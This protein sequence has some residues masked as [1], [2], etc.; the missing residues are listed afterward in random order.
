MYVVF[1][2]LF[3]LVRNWFIVA[4]S[5]HQNK[6]QSDSEYFMHQLSIKKERERERER[7]K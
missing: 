3:V 2:S 1:R 7:L 5:A 4:D 6:S